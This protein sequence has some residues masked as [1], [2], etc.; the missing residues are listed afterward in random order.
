MFRP[1]FRSVF[2][3]RVY[4]G[5]KGWK[6]LLPGLLGLALALA[7]C[8]GGGRP[9]A[10]QVVRGAGFAIVTPA[11]WQVAR[12]PRQITSAP[13]P[14]GDT[15]VSVTAFRLV[16]AYRPALWPKV[17][18]E[19]DRLA[20]E[21]AGGQKARLDASRTVHVLGQRSRQYD[22]SLANGDHPLRERITFFLFGRNEFQLLCRWLESDGEPSACGLLVR[23][24]KPADFG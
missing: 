8:G 14:G 5:R 2:A 16:R 18:P 4:P 23:G 15:L 7:G 22:L 20:G 9:G 10:Q 13:K 11:D 19:L 12:A 6:P 21:L 17:V 1:S 24:F 3:L